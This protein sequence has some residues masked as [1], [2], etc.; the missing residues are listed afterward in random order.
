M[1]AF[2]KIKG[3]QKY[4]DFGQG[5]RH[6]SYE[7]TWWKKDGGFARF[8]TV[9]RTSQS[10]SCQVEVWIGADDGRGFVR[11]LVAHF[12]A[13]DTERPDEEPLKSQLQQAVYE[14][15]ERAAKLTPADLTP[16]QVFTVTTEKPSRIKAIGGPPT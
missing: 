13:V 3:P 2:D 8:V 4:E 10:S 16:K 1:L 7:W 5:E 15:E 14:G 11:H 9:S 6:G 12:D